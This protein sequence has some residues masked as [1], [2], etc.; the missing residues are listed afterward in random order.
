MLSLLADNLISRCYVL[1]D[2]GNDRLE[3]QKRWSRVQGCLTCYVAMPSGYK[4]VITRA[5]SSC[6]SAIYAIHPSCRSQLRWNSFSSSVYEYEK[7]W[8]TSPAFVS[9]ILWNAVC[10]GYK[11]SAAT[12]VC[13]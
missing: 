3:E 6:F 12:Q 2:T 5:L 13:Q 10:N 1:L 8:L 7:F 9:A 11:N 4:L